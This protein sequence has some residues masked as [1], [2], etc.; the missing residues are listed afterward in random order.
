MSAFI[1]NVKKL[2]PEIAF[3]AVTT[4][5]A[6]YGL[7][8]LHPAPSAPVLLVIGTV[9][10]CAGTIIYEFVKQLANELNEKYPLKLL[11]HHYFISLLNGT[12]SLI[13]TIFIR[14]VAQRLGCQVPGFVQTFGY[15][16]LADR[17]N[18]ITKSAVQF[19]SRHLY[20]EPA[21]DRKL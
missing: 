17:I 9:N 10:V 16:T 15:L 5:L 13:S 1:K 4:A 7:H 21:F 8:Q 18:W 6:C 14:Y 19:A 3:D 20:G 2:A 12:V 11:N